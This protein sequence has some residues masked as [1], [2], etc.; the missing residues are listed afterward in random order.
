MFEKYSST[1]FRVIPSV[2]TDAQKDM[3]KLIVAL[4]NLT[5]LTRSHFFFI[6]SQTQK[7][8]TTQVGNFVET[9]PL[10]VAL[11][12]ADGKQ[13]DKILA[14]PFESRIMEIEL[15]REKEVV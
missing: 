10:A 15:D 3:T 2:P 7:E 13:R 9:R 4:R 8:S 12:Q 6:F 14:I 1:K 5:H 11:N